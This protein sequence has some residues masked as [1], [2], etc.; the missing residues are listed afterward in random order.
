MD[1][2]L[3]LARGERRASECELRAAHKQKILHCCRKK[4][5]AAG[6]AMRQ[7]R[8]GGRWE[9]ARERKVQVASCLC[10]KSP[11]DHTQVE[12]LVARAC[13]GRLSRLSRAT[14]ESSEPRCL[15]SSN[16]PCDSTLQSPSLA[17]WAIALPSNLRL[18][19]G[20]VESHKPRD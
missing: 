16:V 4:V 1:V 18:L 13:Q 20:H 6:F 8:D 17:L 7:R 10:G 15:G 11:C 12:F 9:S 5:G 19:H 2:L 3:S 14:L